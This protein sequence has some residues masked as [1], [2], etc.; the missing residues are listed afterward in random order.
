MFRASGA[1]FCLVVVSLVVATLNGTPF[2]P[3]LRDVSPYLLFATTPYFALDAARSLTAQ[4][5]RGFLVAAGLIASLAFAVTWF[6]NRGAAQL[7]T[8][9]LGLPSVLL[10]ASL[11]S[12]G[13]AAALRGGRRSFLWFLAAVAVVALLAVTGTRSAILLLAAPVAI[14]ALARQEMARRVLRLIAGVPLVAVTAFGVAILVITVAH[15]NLS[16][17]QSRL[18][19]VSVTGTQ[20]D[21]SYVSR[22]NEARAAF[23]MFRAAPLTG[24]GPGAPIN[25]VDSFGIVRTTPTVDSPLGYLAKFG[26]LGLVVIVVLAVAFVGVIRVLRNAGAELTSR[27]SLIAFGAVV[28]LWAV[29]QVPFEDKGLSVGM[30]LLLA[31]SAREF[32]DSMKLE[33]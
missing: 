13:A 25:W 20:Y 24:A 16:V 31:V 32:G 29:L 4:R 22:A 3:W 5:L 28:L 14:V 18:N 10:P 7:P 27:L 23:A 2:K 26:I 15:V 9:W 12:Y 21:H 19:L 17:L 33:H 1:L 30:L 6:T 8:G 11:V